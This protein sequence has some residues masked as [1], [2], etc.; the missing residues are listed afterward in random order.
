MKKAI[1]TGGWPNWVLRNHD[2]PRIAARVGAEQAR[3]AAMLLLT[4]RGTP[5]IYY[6][7]ELGLAR[8]AIP[9]EAAKDPWKRNEPGLGLSRDPSRTPMQWNGGANA[10]FTRGARPWLPLDPGYQT[11]NVETMRGDLHSLLNLYREL[12][13]LRR[14]HRSLSVGAFRLL[15]SNAKTLIYQRTFG[16]EHW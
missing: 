9:H 13:D 10:G 6:G 7:D 12:I 11:C 15:A 2:Q 5:T 4:L 3:V 1:P 16:G 8:V 14:S